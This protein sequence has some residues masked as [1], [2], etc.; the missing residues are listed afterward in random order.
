MPFAC[1]PDPSSIY[2]AWQHN[3][4]S[5]EPTGYPNQSSASYSLQLTCRLFWCS[6]APSL[7]AKPITPPPRVEEPTPITPAPVEK[8][9][10]TSPPVSTVGALIIRI[11]FWG[12]LIMI[13]VYYTPKPYSDY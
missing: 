7:V 1:L 6:Q 9:T 5:C 4:S 10:V 3:G 13:I 11:G 2:S 8:S 12:L